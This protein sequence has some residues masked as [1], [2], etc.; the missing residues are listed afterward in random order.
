MLGGGQE[1]FLGVN[2][3]EVKPGIAEMGMMSWVKGDNKQ[4]EGAKEVLKI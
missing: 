1:M 3:I 4:V 2:N